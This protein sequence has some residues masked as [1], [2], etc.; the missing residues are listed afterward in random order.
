MHAVL[1]NRQVAS[2]RAW[3][4]KI[5]HGFLVSS[6]IA[7]AAAFMSDRFGRPQLLYAL[8]MGLGLHFV[9]GDSRVRSD[10]DFCAPTVLRLVV[11]LLGARITLA[12]VAEVGWQT[13]LVVV[14]VASTITLGWW[15]AR[16]MRRPVEE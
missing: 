12:Q 2:G 8:L 14:A 4:Q 13:A 15:L 7:L 11:A 9:A 16:R 1:R 3:L 10:V 6:L 5:G